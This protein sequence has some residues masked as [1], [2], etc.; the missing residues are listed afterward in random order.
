M[1]AETPTSPPSCPKGSGYHNHDCCPDHANPCPHHAGKGK[2]SLLCR[3]GTCVCR[4]GRLWSGRDKRCKLSGCRGHEGS[5]GKPC[6]EGGEDPCPD[7]N[8]KYASALKCR[9]GVCACKNGREWSARDKK[10]KKAGCRKHEGGWH[11]PCCE[12]TDEPCPKSKGSY[13]SGLKCFKGQCSC[14]RGRHWNPQTH[15]CQVK[16]EPESPTD[17]PPDRELSPGMSPP[18]TPPGGASP[19][20][21]A[22]PGGSPPNSPGGSPPGGG[23]SPIE[24]SPGGSPPGGASPPT[25]TSPGNS[26]PDTPPGSPPGGLCPGEPTQNGKHG[27]SCCKD[28]SCPKVGTCACRLCLADRPAVR[29]GAIAAYDCTSAWSRLP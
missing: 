8:G 7:S 10:C 14:K 23:S 25:E 16:G 6:C 15:E 27:A 19:P 29:T 1:L 3:K 17:S 9:Q 21:E 26:P 11:Q 4:T 13:D 18:G 20:T 28:G 24:A 5:F 12:G 2:D 22:S